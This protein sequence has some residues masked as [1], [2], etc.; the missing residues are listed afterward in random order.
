MKLTREYILEAIKEV[1]EE[2]K[3]D[4]MSR[5]KAQK[6]KKA[7]EKYTKPELEN[8]DIEELAD[9]AEENGVSILDVQDGE[10]IYG[11]S[12][13]EAIEDILEAQDD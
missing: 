4:K 11:D 2:G 6:K 1:V 12:S 13:E 10:D 7:R 5:K 3:V 9:V 8:M